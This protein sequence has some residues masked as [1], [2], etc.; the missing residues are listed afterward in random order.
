MGADLV[1]AAGFINFLFPVICDVFNHFL[2]LI[3]TRQFVSLNPIKSI[4]IPQDV[5]VYMTFISNQKDRI[6]VRCSFKP[7]ARADIDKLT[8]VY[9]YAFPSRA[10]VSSPTN[11]QVLFE[12]E[13]TG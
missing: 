10:V 9:G 12:R 1:A 8:P 6:D 7:G 11:L 5:Y 4:K 3:Q 2:R 13:F